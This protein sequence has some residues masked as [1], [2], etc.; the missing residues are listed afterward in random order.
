MPRA[1]KS[2][3]ARVFEPGQ[4]SYLPKRRDDER[5]PD[6]GSEIP[7]GCFDHPVVILSTDQSKK[8]A[9]VLILTSLRGKTLDEYS[10]IPA[11]RA[12][13][14]PIHPSPVHPDNGILLYLDEGLELRRKTYVKTETPRRIP[15]DL[16]QKDYR[17]RK[18]SKR[19]RLRP[20]S[21]KKLL[22][23]SRFETPTGRRKS[24]VPETPRHI[25]VE[26]PPLR[27]LLASMRADSTAPHGFIID[28]TVPPPRVP[29]PPRYSVRA[30]M[31]A[32]AM[33][34]VAR[35]REGAAAEIDR[36]I[37]QRREAR[38]REVSSILPTYRPS[39]R[40]ELVVTSYDPFLIL[41][42]LFVVLLAMVAISFTIA[43][44]QCQ[45]P[46]CK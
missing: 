3:P 23:Y 10:S 1:R 27:D 28:P 18:T 30:P 11:T 42:G 17:E 46:A 45:L 16:L 34:S 41:R 2:E 33:Q 36:D 9:V 31:T 26:N 15:W 35:S 7:N 4:L 43:W 44:W 32:S 13:H 39:P 38:R 6:S 19:F 8:M 24:K 29:E 25:P 14:L 20:E 12:F 21:F 37:A 40:S 5:F 22:E